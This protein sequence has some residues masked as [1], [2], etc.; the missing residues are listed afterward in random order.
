MFIVPWLHNADFWERKDC[1]EFE[2]AVVLV[3]CVAF[4]LADSFYNIWRVLDDDHSAR[5]SF[6]CR[7]KGVSKALRRGAS[8]GS[9]SSCV[10]HCV[11]SSSLVRGIVEEGWGTGALWSVRHWS[12]K[13]ELRK[14]R[15]V[16]ELRSIPFATCMLY[17]FTAT[18]LQLAFLNPE[19]CRG[20]H[21]FLECRPNCR[22]F[23]GSF[24]LI[25]SWRTTYHQIEVD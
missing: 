8:L 20:G 12:W 19:E 13:R 21:L 3:Q 15:S 16:S 11:Q 2:N 25:W 18:H 4:V 9:S 6:L 24:D 17:V 10:L 14:Y 23:C 5:T 22:M 1:H 7:C